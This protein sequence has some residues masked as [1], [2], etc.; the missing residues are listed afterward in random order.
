MASFGCSV[1]DILTGV[2]LIIKIVK[3][4][5]DTKESKSDYQHLVSDLNNLKFV[6]EQ[7]E[8]FTSIADGAI[9]RSHK[10][11]IRGLASKYRGNLQELLD[12]VHKFDQSLGPRPV[13]GV[14]RGH[15]RK[16]Q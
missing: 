8:E 10:N 1:G 7:L 3:T 13:A 9:E 16:Q 11:A 15:Q 12:R 6:F 2:T 5:K 4:L 14:L